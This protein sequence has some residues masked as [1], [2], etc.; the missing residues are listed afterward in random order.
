[1]SGGVELTV[2]ALRVGLVIGLYAFL[3]LVLLVVW[4]GTHIAEQESPASEPFRQ[5]RLVVLEPAASGLSLGTE[6][7]LAASSTIGRGAPNSIILPD[8][9]VSA[10]HGR[11][12]FRSGRWWAEDLQSANG[13]YVN[14][15]KAEEATLLNDG[16]ELEIAQVRLRIEIAQVP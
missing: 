15:V 14:G 3:A 13:T 9:S 11:I 1:M 6:F 7:D 5:A 10:R 12:A 16:D 4:R 8:S 2:L